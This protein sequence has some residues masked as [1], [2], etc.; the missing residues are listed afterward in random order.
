MTLE[1]VNQSSFETI[2]D[3]GGPHCFVSTHLFLVRPQ[4]DPEP[5][6]SD[7]DDG[8]RGHEGRHTGNGGD[9]PWT[10]IITIR[11]SMFP[12]YYRQEISY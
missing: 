8:Q 2:F 7:G 5:V 9:Q 12:D 1:K 6:D 10:I 3:I 11:D 4:D